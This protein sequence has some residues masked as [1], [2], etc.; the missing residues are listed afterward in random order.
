MHEIEEVSAGVTRGFLTWMGSVVNF[1]NVVRLNPNSSTDFLNYSPDFINDRYNSYDD[2][3]FPYEI[4]WKL[5]EKD[6]QTSNIDDIFNIYVSEKEF[7]RSSPEGEWR[8]ISEEAGNKLIKSGRVTLTENNKRGEASIRINEWRMSENKVMI[9]I[10]KSYYKDQVFSQLVL[11]YKKTGKSL[12]DIL[13]KERDR[14]IPELNDKR[15]ANSVGVACMLFCF[16]EDLKKWRPIIIK[17]TTRGAV[18][19][20]S[21][22][23][24]ASGIARWP[25]KDD[26]QSFS[27]FFMDHMYQEIEEEAGIHRRD[28]ENITP[29]AL[30][31]EYVRAGKPQLFFAGHLMKNVTPKRVGDGF[32]D[33]MIKIERDVRVNPQAR[34]EMS[35]LIIP[36][37]EQL[38]EYHQKEDFNF[39]QE[40]LASFA[41]GMEYLRYQGLL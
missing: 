38:N 19:G 34:I 18:Y 31:R 30:C 36:T 12:R 14:E 39:T 41:F 7:K 21:W 15:L 24:T 22:H 8:V 23:C 11:D 27:N 5:Q 28:I 29:M 9:N 4:Y 6:F 16:D 35:D 1:K 20:N 3:E 40:G 25:D 10:Q 17:K 13:S 33:A 37:P 32:K 2:N 26:N